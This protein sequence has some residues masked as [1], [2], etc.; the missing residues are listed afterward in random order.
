MKHP[1][2]SI[3]NGLQ[4]SQYVELTKLPSFGSSPTRAADRTRFTNSLSQTSFVLLEASSIKPRP[5]FGNKRSRQG[6]RDYLFGHNLAG[7]LLGQ[8]GQAPEEAVLFDAVLEVQHLHELDRLHQLV[9]EEL[10][11]GNDRPE[12]VE[13]P[14]RESGKSARR[15]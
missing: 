2:N 12:K 8:S 11:T 5:E 4:G 15:K 9:P 7:Q 1:G 14:P 13:R 3:S 10:C 6:S